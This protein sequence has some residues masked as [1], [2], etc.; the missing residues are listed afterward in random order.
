LS[1]ATHGDPSF[2]AIVLSIVW[3]KHDR[4]VKDPDGV[5]EVQPMLEPVRT[6]LERIPVVDSVT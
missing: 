1:L 5:D 4:S 3:K 2:F 6:I